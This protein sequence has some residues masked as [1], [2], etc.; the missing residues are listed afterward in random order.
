M[1]VLQA[2]FNRRIAATWGL[3]P[4]VALNAVVVLLFCI[5]FY[6]LARRGVVDGVIEGARFS[7]FKVL[8]LLPGLFGFLLITGLPWAISHVGATRVF[9]AVVSAQMLT[10]LL[11]DRFVEGIDLS[12]TRVL[13]AVL[14]VAGV[15]LASMSSE[16]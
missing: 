12:W 4:T 8:W 13:G 16:S 10:S 2:A 7:D 15:V 3:A 9:V 6:F 11:W 14:C 1:A 5:A